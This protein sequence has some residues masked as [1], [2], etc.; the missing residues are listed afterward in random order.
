MIAL[1]LSPIVS[2]MAAG[3]SPSKE[4]N[5]GDPSDGAGTLPRPPDPLD[6]H[7]SNLTTTSLNPERSSSTQ[8]HL[9]NPFKESYMDFWFFLM[10]IISA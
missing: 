5:N 1:P 2:L 10:A 3:G 7:S 8:G 6:K 9:K 4:K